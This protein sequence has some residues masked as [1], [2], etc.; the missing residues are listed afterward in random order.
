[1]EIVVLADLFSVLTLAV[2]A[3]RI[4]FALS[5][6]FPREKGTKRICVRAISLVFVEAKAQLVE[7]LNSQKFSLKSSM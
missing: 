1:M 7:F 5:W 2:C 4:Y 3:K 6:H